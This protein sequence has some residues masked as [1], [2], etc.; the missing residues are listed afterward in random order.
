MTG[1]AMNPQDDAAWLKEKKVLKKKAK[2][3]EDE[4]EVECLNAAGADDKKKKKKSKKDSDDEEE[5]SPKKDKKKKRKE[6]EAVEDTQILEFANEGKKSKVSKSS[7]APKE[8]GSKA[9]QAESKAVEGA[10]TD[11][12][13]RTKHEMKVKGDGIP[14]PFQTF[15]DAALP[16]IVQKS[17][18]NQGYA[19]PSAIQSQ[20]WPIAFAGRDCLAIAKTGSGKTLGYMMPAIIHILK[21]P[22]QSRK[23]QNG[24]PAGPLALVMAPTR[25]LAV[26]INEEGEKFGKAAGIRSCCCYGGASKGP[27]IRDLNYGVDV[28]IATPGRLLDLISMTDRFTGTKVITLQRCAVLVLDEADRMLDMGFEKDIR[29]IVDQIPKTRQTLFFSATWPKAVERIAHDILKNPVQINIGSTDQLIANKDVTQN[30]LILDQ[31][32]KYAE[33]LKILEAHDK[34]S[35]LICFCNRKRDVHD[36]ESKLWE[37]GYRVGSIHGDKTQQEREW[38]LNEFKS[39]ASPVMIATDVAARGLDIKGIDHVVNYDFPNGVEDYVHRIGRTGRAG[40][41]GTAH[42]FFTYADRAKARDLVK[43]MEEAGQTVSDE[44]R[45]LMGRAGPG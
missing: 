11:A 30:V 39:G 12:D 34:D 36:C 1:A 5:A 43:V 6:M 26:Q 40:A 18:D 10:M 9:P 19:V 24:D 13:F 31:N 22:M 28:V 38:T 42:T 41:K 25:E 44:L 32:S 8:A 4:D 35:R 23:K 3:V 16:A 45:T 15:A 2:K 21:M 29:S 17:L 20:A 14:S 37:A 7:E 27:Q 33:L